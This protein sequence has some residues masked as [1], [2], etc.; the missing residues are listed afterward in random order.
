MKGDDD[1]LRRRVRAKWSVGGGRMSEWQLQRLQEELAQ[2]SDASPAAASKGGKGGGG[3]G[4]GGGGDGY[5]DYVAAH[6]ELSVVRVSATLYVREHD[7]LARL[8][9]DRLQLVTK[10]RLH[11]NGVGLQAHIGAVS[12][13][14][15]ASPHPHLRHVLHGAHSVRTSPD[16]T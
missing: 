9:A 11:L 10:Q 2:G 6:I 5:E 4:G 15:L 3:G 7:G 14:D 16:T 12:L 1:A 13:T 8:A